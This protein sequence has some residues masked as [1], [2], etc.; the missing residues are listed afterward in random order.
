MYVHMSVRSFGLDK[1]DIT[2]RVV[3]YI[4]LCIKQC[5]I[6]VGLRFVRG[7]IT[8]QMDVKLHII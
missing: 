1:I 8:I 7:S 2:V 3:V 5:I 4:D 6:Q